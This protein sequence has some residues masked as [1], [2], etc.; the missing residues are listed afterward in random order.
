MSGRKEDWLQCQCEIV[1][2]FRDD[3]DDGDE[4]LK[5]EG[6]PLIRFQSRTGVQ[7]ANYGFKDIFWLLDRS[8]GKKC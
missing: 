7:A 6:Q 4:G 1:V 2:F 5:G 8:S 3:K